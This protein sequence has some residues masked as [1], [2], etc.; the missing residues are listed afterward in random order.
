M[1]ELKWE[2]DKLAI[3]KIDIGG[4]VYDVMLGFPVRM[5]F[6]GVAKEDV[7]PGTMLAFQAYRP[8]ESNRPSRPRF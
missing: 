8:A 2:S 7:E 1:K 5:D 6:R 4:K 3:A